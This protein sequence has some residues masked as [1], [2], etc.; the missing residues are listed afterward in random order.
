MKRD[1]FFED[2]HIDQI[3]EGAFK[4]L[5]EIGVKLDR[6][7]LIEII[8]GKGFRTEGAFIKIDKETA[9]KK[10][11]SQRAERPKPKKEPL[12]TFISPYS[13][14]YENID[15]SFEAITSESNAAMAR[16]AVN[17]GGIWKSLGERSPIGATPPGHPREVAPELQF[18]RQ[19]VNG[20]VWCKNFSPLE[21]VSV[22]TAPH[23]FGLCEAM[24]RPVTSMPIYVSS[25]LNVA[26]ESFDVAYE[27][28]R[29]LS[30][31]WVGSMPS[32]GA[33]A[34]LNLIAAY[35]QTLAENLGGAVVFEEL[36]GVPASFSVNL[37][38][39]DFY[40]L[41]MPFGSPEK[42]LLE[43]INAEVNARV[44][45]NESDGPKGVDIH[46]NAPRCGIQACAEKASLAAAGAMLGATGMGCAGTLGMDEL[47]S[48]VQLLLDLEILEHVQ[49]VVDGMPLDEF[50]G[51]LIA[52]VRDGMK[53]GYV[54]SDR[55]LDGMLDYVW[56]PRFFN[57]KS[58]G[59]FSERPYP[60]ETEKARDFASDLLKKPP[61]YK[62]DD[63]SEL[64]AERIY[65]AAEKSLGLM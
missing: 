8:A 12:W 15:G 6:P 62:I 9:R 54:I 30:N 29:R 21:P 39:F 38:G 53:R 37:F 18:F 64:E 57:R 41:T 26:N 24:G 65:S 58:F 1:Y 25:P 27:N 28:R 22:K 2:G 52:E 44:C 7:K 11:D 34:P 5:E 60:V 3:R 47:F 4:I 48:P 46:T 31:V 50:E 40:E 35:S 45:G 17:A 55:T 23:Y 19:A 20:F 32:L 59:A 56:R 13:H 51:D 10:I 33:T 63:A 49:R 36:S 61:A 43:W 16:F 42:L 14:A